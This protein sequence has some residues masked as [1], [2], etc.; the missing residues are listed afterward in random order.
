VSVTT[1][2]AAPAARANA[3]KPRADWAIRHADLEGPGASVQPFAGWLLTGLLGFVAYLTIYYAPGAFERSKQAEG[4]DPGGVITL[5]MGYWTIGIV[6][7][8]ALLVAFEPL[9][10]RWTVAAS[11]NLRRGLDRRPLFAQFLTQAIADFCGLLWKLPGLVMSLAD[12]TLART[13]A[14]LVGATRHGTAVRY[15][16]GGAV[17]VGAILVSLVAPPALGLPAAALGIIAV[18]AIVRRWSWFESDRDTFLAERGHPERVERVGFR[19]DL[20]DEALLGIVCLFALI[21]LLLRQIQ[22]ATCSSGSCAFVLEGAELP[23]DLLGQFVAWLGYFGAELAKSVPFV[24]WSEVFRVANNSPI[25]PRTTAGAQVA[26]AMRASLDLML[27]A[28]VVQAVGIANRLR[29]QNT[30]FRSNRL[31]ILEPFAEARE[32]ERTGE[33]I[34][35]AL[36]I[37]PREQHAILAFPDYDYERLTVLIADEKV[38]EPARRA[39]VALLARQHGGEETERL[40]FERAALEPVGREM[41]AW[42]LAAASGLPPAREA[43]RHES[44]KQ[45]LC[46]LLND[47]LAPASVRSAAAR[48][49]GRM[50]REGRS[51]ASLLGCLANEAEPAVRADAIVA[52]AKLAPERPQV[53]SLALE[54]ARAFKGKL[55]GE[56]LL[57]AMATAHALARLRPPLNDDIAKHFDAEL[58][59]HVERAVLI[60]GTP[61]LPG[62]TGGELMDQMVRIAPGEPQFPADF[63]MGADYNEREPA[64]GSRSDQAPKQTIS[65]KR[66]YAFGRFP[67][68]NREYR[69]FRLAMGLAGQED[70]PDDHPAVAVSWHDANAYARWL[71]RITG[72][73]YRLPSEAEWEYACRAGTSTRYWWGDEWDDACAP[74]GNR[75]AEVTVNKPNPWGIWCTYGHVYEWCADPWHD[76]HVGRPFSDEAWLAAPVL[77]RVADGNGEKDRVHRVVR[78]GSFNWPTGDRRRELCSSYRNEQ[79]ATHRQTNY[80][81]RLARSLVG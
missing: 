2:A 71:E 37:L 56:A 12:A 58:R 19:Q 9:I 65:M 70:G 78:G 40:L 18:I 45:R 3:G 41:Q 57:P 6:S 5:E 77:V 36:D 43:N 39:A 14:T 67:V 50:S 24:D 59:A 38:R 66:A 51:I 53:G 80:G 11:A 35:T 76:S 47:P 16:W 1:G 33:A 75:N 42:V 10:A 68:T 26:F 31:P 61:M 34:E 72:E 23:P 20:R 64:P 7:A 25:K 13:I 60:Q 55:T 73:R 28:A 74:V 81:F 79:V 4:T 44:D 69:G 52:L 22:L 17:I 29:E 27:L 30:A 49:L 62:E 32:L 63:V 54:L 48:R 15:L 46:D 21:P 8:I